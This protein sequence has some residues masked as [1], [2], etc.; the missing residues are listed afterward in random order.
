[1]GIGTNNPGS[2]L[3][4]KGTLRLSGSSSGYVGFA[5]AA[6]AGSTTYTLPSADGS[7]GQFLKTN[8]AGTLSWASASATIADDSL[9]FDKFVDA[10]TL[11]AATSIAGSGT[12]GLSITQSG[13]VDAL[14]ITNTGSGN[15]LLVE[16]VASTDSSPFVINASGDVGIGTTSPGYKVDV[17]G[18]V[19]VSQALTFAGGWGIIKDVTNSDSLDFDSTDITAYQPLDLLNSSENAS[20]LLSNTGGPGVAQL[21]ITGGNVGIGTNPGS[22]LDVKGTLRLSGATSGY[23][24][25]APAAAAGSMTYTLPSAD[26]SNGQFLKTNGSVTLS[27]ASASATIADDSLDFDKFVDAMALD[28]A[29]SIAGS[30]TNGLSI[31]Q[32]GSVPALKITN[33]GSGASLL[34][35]DAASTDTTP[36][37]ID[38]S[39]NVGIGTT[40]PTAGNKLQVDRG[41]VYVSSGDLLVR[42]SNNGLISLQNLDGDEFT[43]TAMSSSE[44]VELM[45]S[46]SI[47][48][49]LDA[50]TRVQPPQAQWNSAAMLFRHHQMARRWVP[51]A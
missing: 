39:G 16:D 6:A 32:S 35:E 38:A 29:T 17:E 43:I 26:G 11:D 49:G 51:A 1:V 5:P 14:K 10:M 2:R 27:W 25:F 28:A 18:D 20:I 13:S 50:D 31:T 9:D 44:D 19:R 24:G 40:A 21:A 23:V 45:S 46:G 15:S 8:G 37:V 22:T 36:F 48:F 30:G 41:S 42:G 34:V 3:D 47:R 33:T 12:N 7:N 4:V